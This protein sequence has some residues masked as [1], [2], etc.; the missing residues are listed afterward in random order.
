M[1]LSFM[2]ILLIGTLV[3]GPSLVSIF[4]LLGVHSRGPV[5]RRRYALYMGPLS[6]AFTFSPPSTSHLLVVPHFANLPSFQAVR[7]ERS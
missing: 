3:W 7:V 2:S 6:A 1:H 5:A 4:C